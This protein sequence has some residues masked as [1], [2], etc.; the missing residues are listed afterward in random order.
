MLPWIADELS[1]VRVSYVRGVRGG[2]VVPAVLPDGV[3][4]GR[5][6]LISI[7]EWLGPTGECLLLWVGGLLFLVG[8][9]LVIWLVWSLGFG[10]PLDWTPQGDDDE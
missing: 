7:A 5:G 9:A 6:V 1:S 3:G 4:R 10:H 2:P 8:S